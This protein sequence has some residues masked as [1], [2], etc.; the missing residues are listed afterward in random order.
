MAKRNISLNE[1]DLRRLIRKT[2]SEGWWDGYDG[3]SEWLDYPEN[4]DDYTE[5]EADDDARKQGF[6]NW[7]DWDSYDEYQDQAARERADLEDQE[8]YN[9]FQD[10]RNHQLA[11]TG[12][13]PSIP[14]ES[15]YRRGISNRMLESI[16]RRVVR[17]I[18][19][20]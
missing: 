11:D 8:G 3:D 16:T 12:Y 6:D 4:Y 17:K 15:H 9:D 18:L 1:N 13:D 7:R 5:D 14:N 20:K 2:L 10:K 19:R